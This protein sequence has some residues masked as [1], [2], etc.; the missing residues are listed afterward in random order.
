MVLGGKDWEEQ[1]VMQMARLRHVVRLADDGL[2]NLDAQV[3][4]R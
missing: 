2:V 3:P 1:I 4:L